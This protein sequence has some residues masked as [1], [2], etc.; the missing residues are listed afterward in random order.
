MYFI[1]YTSYSLHKRASPRTHTQHT[2]SSCVGMPCASMWCGVMIRH[3]R[4]AAYSMCAKV[5]YELESR[6]VLAHLI[7]YHF[8]HYNSIR[9]S[10]SVCVCVRARHSQPQRAQST[11]MSFG[12]PNSRHRKTHIPDLFSS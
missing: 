10:L 7:K 12:I 3:N 9:L 8:G 1:L 6:H 5:A 4:V 11:C 2:H